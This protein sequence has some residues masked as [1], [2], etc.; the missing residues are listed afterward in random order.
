MEVPYDELDENIVNLVRAV[1]SFPGIF[2]VG[3]C[4][5]HPNPEPIKMWKGVSTSYL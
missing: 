1:N 3:S 2:T 5:G 4:G